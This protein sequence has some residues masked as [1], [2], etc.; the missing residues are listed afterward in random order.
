MLLGRFSGV[1]QMNIRMSVLIAT[2]ILIVI[3]APAVFSDSGGGSPSI[4]GR[5][6]YDVDTTLTPSW[7]DCLWAEEGGILNGYCAWLI[8]TFANDQPDMQISRGNDN[9][10]AFSGNA[11]KT[12]TVLQFNIESIPD[13]SVIND[14][15]LVL[16]VDSIY[17][18]SGLPSFGCN[19]MLISSTEPSGRGT[20]P[21]I[22][23]LTDAL[24]GDMS[25]NKD[26]FLGKTVSSPGTLR[27][28]L[29]D[30][31]KDDFEAQ[32]V[33]NWFAVGLFIDALSGP[34]DTAYVGLSDTRIHHKLEVTYYPRLSITVRTDFDGG[35]VTIDDSIHTTSP[36]VANWETGELH[37]INT[38]SIQTP[39]LGVKYL[40]R[41]WSDGGA[42]RHLI[43]INPDTLEYIAYF[44]TLYQLTLYCP[45]YAN[46]WP[47]HPDS[48]WF[49]P[50]DWSLIK[51]W[52]E[53]TYEGSDS[54]IRHI[55]QG[56]EGTGSGSYTGSN[57]SAWVQLNEPIVEYTVWDTSYWLEL[58]YAGTDTGVPAQIGEGW[59]DVNDSVYVMTQE[60][61][62]VAGAWYFFD[63]W[64]DGAGYLRDS[65]AAHTWYVDPNLP[66]TIIANYVVNPMLEV[67]PEPYMT[68]NPGD[69]FYL[70]A[71]LDADVPFP[72]DSFQF[73][74]H[75]DDT[76]LDYL[77]LIDATIPWA[78]L[79]DVPL[80]GEVTVFGDAPGSVLEIEPP[81]TLFYYE[82]QALIGSSGE[83]TIYFDDFQYAFA[84]A[85]T[86]SG[87]V[88][89]VPED[90]DVTVTTDYGGD[91][92]WIDGTPYPAPFSDIWVGAEA[93]EIG[94]DSL[95]PLAP[96]E[97]ARYIGWD[98]GGA[99]FHDVYP[100]SDS[101]F[102]ALFDTLLL[103]QVISDYGAPAGAGWYDRGATPAFSVAP[104]TVT[105][106]LTRQIF[107]GWE[108]TGDASYTG[109]DNPSTCTMNTP[110]TETAQWQTQHWLELEFTG[111]GGA[112][113]TLTGEGWV[114]EDTWI[115][116]TADST[117]DDGG[118]EYYFAWWSGGDV[119]DRY[120]HEANAYITAP[121]TI[122]AVYADVPFTFALDIPETTIAPPGL[123]YQIPV[124]FDIPAPSELGNIDFHYYFDA[125]LSSFSSVA[126]GD[127]AWANLTATDLSSGSSGHILV[128][129]SSPGSLPVN[130]GDRLCVLNFIA[131]I[132]AG[133]D[134]IIANDPGGDITGATPDTGVLII[135]GEIEVTIETSPLDG[136]V[137]VDG[138][139]WPS[140]RI[141]SWNGYETHGI[142]VDSIQYPT[143][144]VQMLFTDWSDGG[145][146]EHSV[147]PGSDTT[148]TANFALRY[149]L[150]VITDFGTPSGEGYYNPGIEAIFS[151]AP[152]S[153]HVGDSYHLFQGWI[154]VGDESYTGLANP[155]MA[156][157]NEPITETAQWESHH[158]I[159]L[160]YTG[161]PV[162]PTLNGGGWYIEGDTAIIEAQDSIE[163]SGDWYYFIFWQGAGDIFDR[164]AD[165]T[166]A[167]VDAPRVWTA[168]YGDSPANFIFGPPTETA[169]EGDGFVMVPVLF[170]GD[171]IDID[172][173][174]FSIAFDTSLVR[175]ED[176]FDGSF[177]WDDILIAGTDDNP[178]I[179]ATSGTEYLCER[180]DTLVLLLFYVDALSGTIPLDFATP[181]YDLSPGLATD[182][183]IQ[184]TEAGSITV[185]TDFG[186]IV[187]IDGNPRP[188]PYL[189]DWEFGIDHQIGVP[190]YQ[191][192]EPGHRKVFNDWSDGG[193]RL[194]Y[195]APVTDSTFTAHHDDRYYMLVQS[196]YGVVTGSGWYDSGTDAEFEVSP[197]SITLGLDRHIFESW[198]GE[199]PGHYTGTNNPATATVNGVI[200]ETAV[201]REEHYLSTAYAGCAG[202]TPAVSG[203]GWYEHGCWASISADAIAGD[204]IFHYW[205][206]GVFADANSPSTQVR[207]DSAVTV[208][209]VYSGAGISATDSV[210]SLVG[211]T[212]IVRLFAIAS[213]TT[214]L[215]TLQMSLTFGG[216]ILDYVGISECGIGWDILDVT[217][218]DLGG[219][220][221]R[222]DITADRSPAWPVIGSDLLFCVGMEALANGI[223]PFDLDVSHVHDDAFSVVREDRAVIV[224]DGVDITLESATADSL[225]LDG[226]AY[227]VSSIVEVPINSPHI[228]S[229]TSIVPDASGSRFRFEDW[230]DNPNRVRGIRPVGDTTLVA[231]YVQQYLVDGISEMGT[232][233][234]DG[235]FDIDDTA[236][237]AVV[238]DSILFDDSLMY[239]F[240]QWIGDLVSESNPC[241]LIVDASFGIEARWDT[242]YRVRVESD[243]GTAVTDGWCVLGDSTLLQVYPTEVIEG[244]SRHVFVDWTGLGA[245]SYSGTEDSIWLDPTGPVEETANWSL[246]YMLMVE[247]GGRGTI[248]GGG[249]VAD[250]DTAWFGIGPRII[251]STG[252]IR[253]VFD[254]WAGTGDSS[255]SG[256]D[257][258]AYCRVN[259]PINETATWREEFFLAV[260]DGGY[261]TATGSGWYSSGDSAEF[262]V[263]PDS[264]MVTDGIVWI[265]D[266]WFGTGLGSYSGEDNPAGCWMGEP[267]SETATWNLKYKLTMID[268]G[269]MGLPELEGAGW[270][271]PHTWVPVSA[272]PIVE[273]GSSRLSF[274]H[275]SGAE[276]TDTMLTTTDALVDTP[277]TLVAHYANFEVSPPA[278]MQ[279]Q[280]GDTLLMPAILYYPYLKQLT[281]I[282]L[283]IYFPDDLLEYVEFVDSPTLVWST[284]VP[285]IISPG[286]LRVWANR[287]TIFVEP[288]ETLFQIKFVS[289]GS[290]AA[291]DT[292]YFDNLQYDLS[293][294]NTIPG[295][296]IIGA[297]IDVRVESDYAG[298]GNLVRI[299]GTY[300]D[301]PYEGSWIAGDPHE[302]S[303]PE[304]YFEGNTRMAWD[305][306]NDGGAMTHT[307]VPLTSD[308]FIAHYDV[309]HK[310]TIDAD[311]GTP[312][313]GGWY[314]EGA[315]PIFGLDPDSV[316]LTDSEYIFDSWMGTGSGS[317][318]G[319]DNPA[320]C[321]MNEPIVEEADYISRYRLI[322]NGVHSSSF[323]SGWF[324]DGWSANFG[325]DEEIVDSTEG[326]RWVFTG[327]TGAYS[328]S[329]NPANWIVNGPNTQTA[330]WEL[331]YLLTI[332][333]AR[334]TP[335]GGGWYPAGAV[336]EFSIDSTVDSIA[337]I[338]FSLDGWTSPDGGYIGPDNPAEVTMTGPITQVAHWNTEYL[339]E[340]LSERGTV[341][342]G[343]WYLAG[344]SAF[345]AVDPETVVIGG[346][347]QVF[348][349]WA[350]VGSA[351]YTGPD[352]PRGI[353]MD[354]PVTETATWNVQHQL[355]VIG[356][357]SATTGAGWYYHGANAIFSVTDETV[358]D[359]G[360]RATFCNWRGVGI[361]SYTG[362][363]NP[364]S[365]DMM[366]SII[367]T[368]VFDTSFELQVLSDH[369]TPF[370]AGYVPMGDSKAFGVVPDSIMGDAIMFLFANWT[371]IGAGSYTGVANPSVVWPDEPVTETAEWDTFF[372]LTVTVSECGSAVPVLDGAGW[373]VAGWVDISAES[374]VYDGADRYHFDHWAGGVFEDE[375]SAETRV[376]LTSPDTI[377][378]HYAT[379]EVSPAESVFASAGDT[380]WIP[381]IIYDLTGPMMIDSIGFDFLYDTDLLEYAVI[382]EDPDIDW[383][384]TLGMP[385]SPELTVRGFN[386]SEF[387]IDPAETLLIL[388]FV[389]QSGGSS[390]SPTHCEDMRYDI[391]GAGSVDGIFT[392]ID[393]VNVEVRT[394]GVTDSV[395]VDGTA[396]YSPFNTIWVPGESHDIGVRSIVP[397]DEGVRYRFIDW[398]DNPDRERTVSANSDTF[399][400]ANFGT[401]YRFGVFNSGGSSPEPAVGN[402]WFDEGK[403]VVAKVD[404][405]DPI[406]HWA[407]IGYD[408]SGDL[409]GGGAEDS[410]AFNITQ[411]TAIYWLWLQ[412]VPLFVECPYGWSYPT[413]GTTWHAVGEL[414]DAEADSFV[415]LAPDSGMLC[416]GYV[417]TGDTPSGSGH[418]VSFTINDASSLTWEF[419]P[420][421]RLVMA[422]DG[423]GYGYPAILSGDGYYETD[424]DADIAASYIVGD[425]L[426]FDEWTSVPAGATFGLSSDTA[427]TVTVDRPMAAIANY[428]RGSL[429]ELQ[430]SPAESFGGF[431]IAG[432][433]FEDT[434]YASAWVPECWTG[435]IAT[436][437]SD[438]ADGGDSLWAFDHWSD[439]GASEHSAGPVCEDIALT[440]YMEKRYR[441]R[442]QKNPLWD[443]YGSM[444]VDGSTITGDGS[445][446]TTLWWAEGGSH[447]IEASEIDMDAIDKRLVWD[448]WND[449]G[450]RAH[451]VGP[452][453]GPDSLVAE[454][455]REYRVLVQ[456]DPAEAH[457]W[458]DFDGITHE[459]VL[460]ASEWYPA[461]DPAVVEVSTPDASTDTLWTFDQWGDGTIT[462]VY[463]L[464]DVDTSYTLVASYI[465]EIVVLAFNL[466]STAWDIGEIDPGVSVQ[467]IAGEEIPITNIG[468]Q[469]LI[470]GLEIVDSAGWAVG[471]GNGYNR[472]ALKGRFDDS[473]TPPVIWELIDDAILTEPRWATDEIFG[474]GGFY[475]EPASSENLW[476]RFTAPTS[477]SAYDARE[478]RVT[479][480][481]HIALP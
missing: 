320:T 295:Q 93:Y 85:R 388:G 190:E 391:T 94:V 163:D 74:M 264:E 297:P 126:V 222:V 33:D 124:M 254:G 41:Y 29:N 338:R 466:G 319:S 392:R 389:V 166:G 412:Q 318:S 311:Y 302:I 252:T 154:G 69:I 428:A 279:V 431:T 138:D 90:V 369:G 368:A 403:L 176:V 195:V 461:G 51:A 325:V 209:A 366:E 214:G 332:E 153:V 415:V 345:F 151:V 312:F 127:L 367:E 449:A 434:D 275:W 284:V 141:E 60:S 50:R 447:D 315:T 157:V 452:I 327:W 446:D 143:V 468:T 207:V 420:A 381:I 409:E 64:A 300:Y 107:T 245:G 229:A 155:S 273:S 236:Y 158:L 125:S 184:I 181:L 111:A 257:S 119:D 156:T 298:D 355:A 239:N 365:C 326:I 451:S 278:E 308:T 57:D 150:S 259:E 71:I 307:V 321:T 188:S 218:I 450:A 405:P 238:P 177:H 87:I 191:T 396:H 92:V 16:A 294:A 199:G 248:F 201:W 473:T 475:V 220:V 423:C 362:T 301:S 223:A 435:N 310:L 233:F 89:I 341:S 35:W 427:T 437:T 1:N 113:P 99:R 479:I 187:L 26:Y 255:Y 361:G 128:Q 194:H 44:D 407:C 109:L 421:Y 454:Y 14:I 21:V 180:G 296:L 203:D 331:Q 380:A 175:L 114:D 251:D 5:A 162:A 399:F 228:A 462:P 88:Q 123:A 171:P 241:T 66:R 59:V 474:P 167:S 8:P 206:G 117:V 376:E 455:S 260:N 386:S 417:G 49:E 2:L 429:I 103:L 18:T 408:G 263:D 286:R 232:I 478:I 212:A 81:E 110:I 76:R 200:S 390:T 477:S 372:N 313:G 328:G 262:S 418:S 299:D 28:R 165:S 406:S 140:P 98:D 242:L 292:I 6:E 147:A 277:C 130:P 217:P 414:V 101:T 45:S 230:D 359:S 105:T 425:S 70:P 169:S 102:T 240:E 439:E 131:G 266:S 416:D 379:F 79:T 354:S 204:Y 322:V 77:G 55:F 11:R 53:T 244:L 438:T 247:N 189:S 161:T 15:V 274:L 182:G 371:G 221:T 246:E 149:K 375:F 7:D 419:V 349:G 432:N 196:P 46:V 78:E 276:V 179:G 471:Y 374:P 135:P 168:V 382:R 436:T 132:T 235:W 208:T 343:G 234:G 440:A 314:R 19:D 305:N 470:L 186:G 385:G 360:V 333:S 91:S 377:T 335:M 351:S 22:D 183:V 271:T 42:K 63:Y 330:T 344:D 383:E 146:R 133:L 159:T 23:N 441:I 84:D 442:L 472:F 456:K 148:F 394:A 210:W 448:N 10:G 443:T 329:D 309:E 185:Q 104:E 108:G 120:N 62:Q 353:R 172:S 173:I 68:V 24:G 290:D 356:G 445:A 237:V 86:D 48:V 469:G 291:L 272:P 136:W 426:F 96:G 398:D 61:L 410:V 118:T 75:Y 38:D 346:H 164:Y 129:A 465:E 265:F 352:N 43:H 402:H 226:T 481:G 139:V 288:P 67:F 281:T 378:A 401:Q 115:P 480:Y 4:P 243:Y 316:R 215:D 460:E 358:D 192:F 397:G 303:V 58:D 231:N 122:T 253:Y 32:L 52:P 384:T 283:D 467:M 40:Y 80:A 317:Y 54:L 144:D 424:T 134:S 269:A 323:G 174:G 137:I 463:N 404:N 268:S 83:D 458:I 324:P 411:P 65:T 459:Y 13:T 364:A 25:T 106:D 373:H 37:Y 464:A 342:G 3:N 347:R 293:G 30:D 112:T 387:S 39:G 413:A 34:D 170:D 142:E 178:I 370:G 336:T 47:T 261:S 249:W 476:I 282:Q 152:E 256:P 198:N 400:E 20:G 36:Y 31:A 225:N 82:M 73:T 395:W 304:F 250:G 224:D 267:I 363:G 453:D 213:D 306:W 56:W 227:V 339:L 337:G 393:G 280:A 348:G 216:G 145:E 444:I 357:P 97:I 287:S 258:S 12:C 211:D 219:G 422:V 202:E 95:N 340:V 350:G 160:D 285:G 289:T 9:C 457:G 121:D 430:K 270:H 205:N 100:I 27:V 433:D 197:T 72:T 17:S 334:G 193:L 116:I